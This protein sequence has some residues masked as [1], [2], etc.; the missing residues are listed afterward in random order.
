MAIGGGELHHIA[1]HIVFLRSTQLGQQ[2]A[3][4]PLLH[5]G[6]AIPKGHTCGQ[7]KSG[8][9]ALFQAHQARFHA[10]RQ[11]A[12][13][14]RQGGGLVLKGVDEGALWPCQSVVQRQKGSGLYGGHGVS[15]QIR[16]FNAGQ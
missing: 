14:Q 5:V 8:S 10:G 9:H 15:M 16:Q 13:T 3:G 4:H 6:V 12:R 1:R 11:L 2:F 7:F